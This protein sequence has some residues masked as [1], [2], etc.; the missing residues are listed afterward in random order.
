MSLINGKWQ[1]AAYSKD[2]AARPVINLLGDFIITGDLNGDGSDEAVTLLNLS[3]GG[4]GQW[5]YLAVVSRCGSGVKN[6]ATKF[7]G[8]RV[9]IR[10]GRIKNRSIALDVVRTSPSD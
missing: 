4:T 2:S 10:G 5:L 1:G 3:T 9:Q 8:D 7:I 6:I